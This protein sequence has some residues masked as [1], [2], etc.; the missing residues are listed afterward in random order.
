MSKAW[1]QPPATPLWRN[2]AHLTYL[3]LLKFQVVVSLQSTFPLNCLNLLGAQGQINPSPAVSAQDRLVF[4]MLVT[5][6]GQPRRHAAEEQDLGHGVLWVHPF[7]RSQGSTASCSTQ[8]GQEAT[9]LWRHASACHDASQ[10]V[11]PPEKPRRATACPAQH[12]PPARVCLCTACA[13]DLLWRKPRWITA[14]LGDRT[15]PQQVIT[16]ISVLF[17]VF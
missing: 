9:G 12:N 3:L 16:N 6:E 5:C 17:N 7:W 10:H 2:R 14:R 15:R 8:R 11:C 13:W 1:A 4:E